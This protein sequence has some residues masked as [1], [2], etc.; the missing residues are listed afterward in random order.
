MMEPDN[1]GIDELPIE[2]RPLMFV[3]GDLDIY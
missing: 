2:R 1:P 3:V